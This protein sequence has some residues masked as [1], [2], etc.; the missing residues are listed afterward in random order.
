MTTP[1]GAVREAREAEILLTDQRVGKIQERV[2]LAYPLLRDSDF[3]TWI[4]AAR[5]V[6]TSDGGMREIDDMACFSICTPLPHNRGLI[7]MSHATASLKDWESRD[8]SWK[9]DMDP[10]LMIFL[11]LAPVAM[12]NITNSSELIH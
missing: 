6:E 11:Q 7:S 3:L 4:Q 9:N 1:G 10:A 8:E 5:L 12:Q 2:C